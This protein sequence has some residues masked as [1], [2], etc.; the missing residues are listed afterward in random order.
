MR[1]MKSKLH[2]AADPKYRVIANLL[3]DEIR[4]GMA[5]GAKLP[6][7]ASLAERF[8]VHVLTIREALRVLQEG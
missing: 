7:E 2:Q 4:R 5:I 6:S 8:G 3:R 1:N